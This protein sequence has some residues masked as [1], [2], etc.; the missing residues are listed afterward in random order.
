MQKIL[1]SRTIWVNV[2]ALVA[3]LLAA[4]GIADFGAEAQASTVGAIMGAA[5]IILRFV[6]KTPIV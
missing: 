3:S 2:V 1:K 5:N 4:F 6:T